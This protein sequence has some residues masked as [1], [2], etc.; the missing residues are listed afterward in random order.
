L[1]VKVRGR[2]SVKNLESEAS[3]TSWNVN[4]KY[5]VSLYRDSPI[6]CIQPTNCHSQSLGS[7]DFELGV[8]TP[9]LEGEF[10]SAR[11]LPPCVHLPQSTRNMVRG[12]RWSNGSLLTYRFSKISCRTV[13]PRI[14]A[15]SQYSEWPNLEH[16]QATASRG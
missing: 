5:A 15:D 7:H 13:L 1:S 8:A 14:H 10:V 9:A 16:Q 3:A 6:L 11:P 12:T 2:S 4:G